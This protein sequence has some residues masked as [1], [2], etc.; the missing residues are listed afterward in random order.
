MKTDEQIQEWLVPLFTDITGP[1]MDRIEKMHVDSRYERYEN[2]NYKLDS[3]DDLSIINFYRFFDWLKIDWKSTESGE[4]Q[5]DCEGV[6]DF[7]PLAQAL[8]DAWDKDLGGNDW[9]PEMLG[10]R[11]LDCFYDVDGMVGFFV[12]RNDMKGLFLFSDSELYPL[13]VNFEGYLKLLGMSKGFGWWQNALVQISTGIHKPNV[14]SFKEKMLQVFPDFSW[15]Q[16]VE[17]Y[18]SLRIDK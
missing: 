4:F 15:N 8:S 6:V 3:V 13:H 17:L 12:G 5:V 9:A 11:P 2:E 1:L 10:F 7:I 16:F 14:D 18:E